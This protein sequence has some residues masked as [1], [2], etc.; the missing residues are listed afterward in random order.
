MFKTEKH[1]Q[2]I[3]VATFVLLF[4]WNWIIAFWLIPTFVA[5]FRGHPHK[6][7]IFLGNLLIGWTPLY[8]LVLLKSFG[9]GKPTSIYLH[10]H[11]RIG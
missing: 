1:T 4:S 8:I 9:D 7:W 2:V 5:Y 3:V 6:E 11:H 10:H